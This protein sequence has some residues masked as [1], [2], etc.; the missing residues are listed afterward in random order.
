MNIK[1]VVLILGLAVAVA[2]LAVPLAGFK[3]RAA[4]SVADA[5]APLP[6]TKAN[7]AAVSKAAAA[8]Q[9]NVAAATASSQESVGGKISAETLKALG[10]SRAKDA[11]KSSAKIAK[12]LSKKKPGGGDFTTQSGQPTVLDARSALSVALMTTIGGRDNQ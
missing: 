7:A 1:R 6:A 3:A 11:A 2:A 4:G 5:R 8:T 9:P 10:I 12:T